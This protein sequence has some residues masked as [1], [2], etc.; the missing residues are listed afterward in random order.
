MALNEKLS[1]EEAWLE[2]LQSS[3]LIGICII[4]EDGHPIQQYSDDPGLRAA[5][6]DYQIEKVCQLRLDE[7]SIAS[8]SVS[9]ND[10]QLCQLRQ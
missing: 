8:L 7:R 9:V 2:Q 3:R 1:A 10:V 6:L 4:D 5:I